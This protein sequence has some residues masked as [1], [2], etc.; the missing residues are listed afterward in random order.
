M[1]QT[2]HYRLL[3]TALDNGTLGPIRNITRIV[4][5]TV[6]T[7]DMRLNYN[8]TSKR[9]LDPGKLTAT[10]ILR[11]SKLAGVTPADV[12]KLIVQEITRPN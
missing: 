4:P 1:K 2:N 3:K 10:D 11:L 7:R 9:L 6:L 12:L 8:T 5:V